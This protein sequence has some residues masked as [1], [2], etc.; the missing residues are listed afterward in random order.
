[1]PMPSLESIQKA[2]TSEAL[3]LVARKDNLLTYLGPTTI[4]LLFLGTVVILTVTLGWYLSNEITETWIFVE[5]ITVSLV[6]V[7]L[8][9]L[10]C[11]IVTSS[12]KF[13]LSHIKR[14]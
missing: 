14:A 10:Y 12:G 8:F 9:L 11:S 5:S 13:V 4:L 6:A 7:V 2:Q 3:A 1:M